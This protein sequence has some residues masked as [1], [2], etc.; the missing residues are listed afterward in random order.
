VSTIDGTNNTVT[1]LVT[2][3]SGPIGVA[4]NEA[5]GKIY[6]ANFFGNSVSVVVE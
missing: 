6:A 3:G 4:L 5:T 2:V 1:S